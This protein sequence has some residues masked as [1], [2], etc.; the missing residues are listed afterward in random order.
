MKQN[1][2]QREQEQLKRYYAFRERQEQGRFRE[3]MSEAEKQQSRGRSGASAMARAEQA[4]F[5]AEIQRQSG[6]NV[7]TGKRTPMFSWEVAQMPSGEKFTRGFMGSYSPV[8]GT[9]GQRSVASA[10]APQPA[11][12]TFNLFSPVPSLQP[13]QNQS[14]GMFG[15]NT[16]NTLPYGNTFGS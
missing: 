3:A 15:L 11:S 5:G 6:V 4:K 1:L 13:M 14:N 7:G 8:V 2:A 9:G 16:F 10:Q 12:P